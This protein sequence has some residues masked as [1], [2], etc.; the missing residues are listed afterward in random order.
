[1]MTMVLFYWGGKIVRDRREGIS[2]DIEA[3]ACYNVDLGISLGGLRDIIIPKIDESGEHINIKFICRYP[4]RRNGEVWIY[5]K[6]LVKDDETLQT[7]LNLPSTYPDMYCVEM[8]IEKDISTMT[9]SH[10]RPDF[11][12]GD[13]QSY[14][15]ILAG[16]DD[17]LALGTFTTMLTVGQSSRSVIPEDTP[18]QLMCS[19]FTSYN[20]YS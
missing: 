14:G 6:L 1:M 16:R 12:W 3:S 15:E 18:G 20:D 5:K 9:T 19:I 4:V 10:S 2:Y 13:V 8:Y 11:N 17:V 7:V